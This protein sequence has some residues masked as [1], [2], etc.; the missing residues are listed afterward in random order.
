MTIFYPYFA[1]K[2]TSFGKYSYVVNVDKIFIRIHIFAHNPHEPHIPVSAWPTLIQIHPPSHL[3][4][5]LFLERQCFMQR[6]ET[7]GLR[8]FP[9]AKISTCVLLTAAKAALPPRSFASP[10]SWPGIQIRNLPFSLWCINALLLTQIIS[11]ALHNA[12]STHISSLCT[13]KT[14]WYVI[15]G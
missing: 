10:A 13:L 4:N 1:Q 14:W 5:N 2:M 9:N 11:L 7:T 6:G 15:G 12:Y 8:T 3:V